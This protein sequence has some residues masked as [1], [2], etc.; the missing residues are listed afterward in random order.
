MTNWDSKFSR[1]LREAIAEAI[2]EAKE[3]NKKMTKLLLDETERSHRQQKAA[4]V[5]VNLLRKKHQEELALMDAKLKDAQIK[6]ACAAPPSKESPLFSDRR[7]EYHFSRGN[8]VSP[9]FLIQENREFNTKNAILQDVTH[10]QN[11]ARELA[12]CLND[13][14]NTGWMNAL[15][16]DHESEGEGVEYE[17]GNR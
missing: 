10:C 17:E 13:A 1:I 12:E 2:A 14:Y 7:Y 16:L 9:H 3:D 8:G 4:E 5:D 6:L 15:G 11:T